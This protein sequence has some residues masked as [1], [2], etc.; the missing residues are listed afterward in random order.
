MKRRHSLRKC[1]NKASDDFTRRH[2]KLDIWIKYHGL[3][4]WHESAQLSL[5]W[6]RQLVT[7]WD[8]VLLL[9]TLFHCRW[10]NLNS[11]NKFKPKEP[12]ATHSICLHQRKKKNRNTI[13]RCCVQLRKYFLKWFNSKWVERSVL[14]SRERE[15]EPTLKNQQ[16][17]APE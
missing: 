1:R 9:G 13:T 6:W 12:L 8:E 15:M 17:V 3:N 16:Q 4:I 7:R 14:L 2:V 10:N 11:F 5:N